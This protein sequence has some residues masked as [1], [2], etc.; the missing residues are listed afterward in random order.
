MTG[1]TMLTLL[2]RCLYLLLTALLIAYAAWTQW[3]PQ[4]HFL[5]DLRSS[6]AF[7]QGYDRGQGNLLG[8]QPELQSAD[9]RSVPHL[10]RKLEAYLQ[11]A[12]QLGL[13]N[14]KTIVILP[15]H[16]GTGLVATGEKREVFAARDLSEA[17]LW[18]GLSHPLPW[19]RAALLS[20]SNAPFSDALLRLK[21]SQMAADYQNL[22]G[23]LAKTYNV[24]IVAGSIVLPEPKVTHNTLQIGNGPLYNVSLVFGNNGLPLGQ[25]QYKVQPH[26]QED[27]FITA[28]REHE[29][30]AIGTPAGRL[31]VLIGTDSWSPENYPILA[32]QQVELLAIPA[33]QPAPT[34]QPAEHET[35]QRLPTPL[36]STTRASMLV[37]LRGQLWGLGSTGRSMA[38]DHTGTQ[39]V[40]DMPGSHLLN[41]WL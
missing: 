16:I 18:L 21:A 10:R 32:K 3:R 8:I 11:Q 7:S 37:F 27:R 2:R 35:W 29:P 5:S 31:G 39:R 33:F 14:P 4:S 19:L 17:H 12:Q 13:L 38:I 25:P 6:L 36:Q 26:R 40:A 22:F 1:F 41:L 23:G 28:G 30:Q 20:D 15:E 9:Y 34:G 24:T